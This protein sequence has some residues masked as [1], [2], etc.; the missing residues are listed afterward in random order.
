ME[1]LNNH[2]IKYIN[3]CQDKI[4]N[5]IKPIEFERPKP[6]T[7]LKG[8]QALVGAIDWTDKIVDAPMRMSRTTYDGEIVSITE[9]YKNK[10][11]GFDEKDFK[12][13]TK[14]AKNI[15]KPNSVNLF[16]SYNTI[17][18]SI[19]DWAFK[20]YKNK[21]LKQTLSKFLLDKLTES[22]KPFN[23][24]FPILFLDID[25]ALRI[26]KVH[27][28]YFTK[29]HLNAIKENF[30]KNHP[31]KNDSAD[32]LVEYLKGKVFAVV[33]IKA[34]SQKAKEVAYNEC[35]LAI[36]CMR[37]CSPIMGYPKMISDFDLEKNS[38]VVLQ[39]DS[40]WVFRQN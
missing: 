6:Q 31:D 21:R 28:R 24:H 17:L 26:G 14:L 4:V 25:N 16:I 23:V 27:I 40:I 22:I 13:V 36:D 7:E 10:N 5:L 29:E 34:E 20:K 3:E 38:S 30:N 15:Y 33:G 11:Y 32:A 2:I 12:E 39:T 35:L 8:N 18:N 19:L 1:Y 37:I 9:S